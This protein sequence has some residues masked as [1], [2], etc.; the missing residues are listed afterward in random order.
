[1]RKIVNSCIMRTKCG[2]QGGT[3]CYGHDIKLNSFKSSTALKCTIENIKNLI[4][5][6]HTQSK[7]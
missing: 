7:H 1:M 5:T 2:L 6:N 3:V 4:I